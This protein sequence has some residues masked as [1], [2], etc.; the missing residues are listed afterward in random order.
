MSDQTDVFSNTPA[1]TTADQNQQ[2]VQQPQGQVQ[3]PNAELAHLLSAIKNEQGQQKYDNL[4]KA[5]EGLANAQ[6]FIPQLKTELQQK[7]QELA[8]LRAELEKRA[9]VE[10]VI[11]RLTAQQQQALPVEGTPPV[12]SGL[13]EQ[14]VVALVLKQLEQVK[15]VDVAKQNAA[16][17]QQALKQQ[18]GD[19]ATEMVKQK[20]AELGT[21]PQELG[22]LASRN[23]A[24]V[25][26]LFN[27]S[28]T[29][30][31]KPTTGSVTIPNMYQPHV[32]EV[33]KP[34]KSLLAGATAKEQMEHMLA[35][36]RAVYAKHGITE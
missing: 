27:A 23:P 17:V 11:S 18:Y 32:P 9:S 2:V 13:D 1:V 7:E 24:M 14:A 20:A 33:P 21:T 5:L 22:Q 19:G 8:T 6:Q 31:L 28:K 10:D 16:Q 36:K 15:Q 4:P 26:A 30:S 29:N 35:V 25:L 34:T 3:D 12:T